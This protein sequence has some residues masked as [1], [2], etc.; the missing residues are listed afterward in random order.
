MYLG[1]VRLRTP[2]HEQKRSMPSGFSGRRKPPPFPSFTADGLD[3]CRS[4][5]VTAVWFAWRGL[6]LFDIEVLARW[7]LLTICGRA[8][9]G[10][11]NK[12]G[13]DRAGC[14]PVHLRYALALGAGSV[15]TTD[16]FAG[17]GRMPSGL[18]V[19]SLAV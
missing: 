12:A 8:G 15:Q 19:P 9:T 11:A 14:R 16:G 5:P 13:L 4:Q 6:L 2:P 7:R 1:T 10:G 17:D 3:R 18:C